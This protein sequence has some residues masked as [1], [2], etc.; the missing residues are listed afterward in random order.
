MADRGRLAEGIVDR[1]DGTAGN[2]GDGADALAF[3]QPYGDLGAVQ[4]VCHGGSFGVVGSTGRL[5]NKTPAGLC[6]RGLVNSGC[7]GLPD[8]RRHAR[9]DAYLDYAYDD[10][11]HCLGSGGAEGSGSV[12]RG[13]FR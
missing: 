3:K 6:R 8:P 10:R 7:F 13:R 5:Q 2:T 1:Q 4:C 12:H 9:Y 11:R